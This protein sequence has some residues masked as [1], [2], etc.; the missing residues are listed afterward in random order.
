MLGTRMGKGGYH[1]AVEQSSL[2]RPEHPRDT[3]ARAMHPA[4]I[5]NSSRWEGAPGT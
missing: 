1:K 2:L 5:L 3:Q 4:P